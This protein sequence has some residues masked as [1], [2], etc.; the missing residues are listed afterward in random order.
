M[1]VGKYN[2]IVYSMTVQRDFQCQSL[3]ELITTHLLLR[4]TKWVKS[5]KPKPRENQILTLITQQ[6]CNSLYNN[7]LFKYSTFSAPG[8]IIGNFYH[9]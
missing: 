3:K 8:D 5:V 9:F 4:E 6:R 1:D 7:R 2:A